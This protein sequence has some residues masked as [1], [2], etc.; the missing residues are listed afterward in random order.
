MEAVMEDKLFETVN[1]WDK[2][3]LVTLTNPR[4]SN[5]VNYF[6]TEHKINLYNNIY[7]YKC[8]ASLKILF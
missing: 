6:S 8:G 4:N 1:R 3:N 5:L 7:K 2:T